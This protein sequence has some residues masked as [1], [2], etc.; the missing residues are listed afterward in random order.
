[1]DISAL[2]FAFTEKLLNLRDASADVID[3]TD[4]R[5]ALAIAESVVSEEIMMFDIWH[6]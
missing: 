5:M 1:M 2:I 4:Q 3:I 6:E